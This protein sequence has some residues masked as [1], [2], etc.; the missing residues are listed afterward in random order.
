MYYF[1]S[2]TKYIGDGNSGIS[3]WN[4]FQTETEIFD[5]TG[6]IRAYLF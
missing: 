6:K 3:L 1:K 2:Y 5:E 4:L